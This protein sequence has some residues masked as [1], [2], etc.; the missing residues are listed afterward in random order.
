MQTEFNIAE[1][2]KKL[3]KKPGVYLMHDADDVIIY[4]GKAVNLYNRVH[5]YFQS[6]RGKTNKILQMVSHIRWFEYI[7]TDS[8]LEALVLECNLIKEN[9]PRYNTMLMDDKAYPYIKVTVGEAFP[10]VQFAH[11]MRRDGARYFGPYTS[12]TAVKDTIGLIRRLYRVRTCHRVLPRDIGAERACLNYHIH[13]CDAP[14][15]GLVSQEE[16]GERIRGILDFLGGRYEPVLARLKEQ[17]EAAAAELDFE[18]AAQI[19]ELYFSVQQIAQKQKI[20]DA[21][22]S[23]DRDVF[24]LAFEETDAA[25]EIFFIRGGRMRGRD[26]VTLTVAEG[27]GPEQILSDLLQQF[28]AGTP[29]L[30]SEILLATEL[31][32]REALEELFSAKAGHKVS[33]VTPKKG[34]KAKLLRLAEQNAKNALEKDREKDRRERERTTGAVS[35][36]CGLL[37]LPY[38]RR[39][40]AYDISHISGF[41]SVG[42]MVAYEDGRPKRSDYR[43]FRIRAVQGNDDYASMDEVLTRRLTHG[44]EE[45]AGERAT[46]SFSDL[47]DLICMDGGRGQVSRAEDVIGRLGL[48]IPVCGMV[49]DDRHRTRA[50]YYQGRELPIDAKSEEF[51][52]LTRIQDE[53][54]RFAITYQRGVRG[55]EQ[56]HSMLDDIPGVGPARRKGLMRR[57]ASLEEIREAGVEQLMEAEGM[58]RAAAEKVYAFFHGP[59]KGQE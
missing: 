42:A 24:A 52:L 21:E 50:L 38:A 46:A 48:S 56:V 3:P 41:A 18:T 19:R 54:H 37:G 22:G 28:Y 6:S 1:E 2:L 13:Q 32:D 23:E 31:P 34:E 5:Q 45:Q 40:E 47:P 57:F 4:V 39:L 17:M 43:K 8:E 35:S 10:R 11:Q 44:L 36:L 59:Q 15:Q 58:N 33:L 30:P 26:R 7:I 51:K 12:S 55:R 27:D 16:Y 25:A 20:T 9:R 53:V 14:C 49:K 29:Q